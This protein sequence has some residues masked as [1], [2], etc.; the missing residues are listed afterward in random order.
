MGFHEDQLISMHFLFHNDEYARPIGAHLNSFI[1]I[2]TSKHLTF[3]RFIS[4]IENISK[5]HKD[6]RVS[7]IIKWVNICLFNESSDWFCYQPRHKIEHCS[8]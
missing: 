4:L 5:V 6:Y 8:F 3:L 2:F 7:A 1:I